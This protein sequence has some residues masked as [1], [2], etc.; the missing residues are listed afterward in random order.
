[1]SQTHKIKAQLYDN[2]LTES[3][4]DY[5]AKVVSEKSLSVEDI[6]HF[7]EAR[8]GSDISAP[9]MAH[10][11][12]LWQKE[13]ACRLCD[14]FAVSTGYF[15][16]QPNIKGVFNSP[17]ETYNPDKH[18][19]LFSFSQGALLRKELAAVEVD[20]TG[21]AN[22]T[23]IISQVIDVKTGSVN[24][25]LTPNR[26]LKILGNKLK[27]LGWC[28]EN[29]V[30]FLNQDTLMQTKVDASDIVT[31]NPSEL[32]IIIP[33]LEVGAYKVRVTTQYSSGNSNKQLLKEPRTAIFEKILTVLKG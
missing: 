25:L 11:V 8:D 27:I 9:V 19:V 24:E 7:A 13:M 4:N 3:P 22:P 10:A 1:M 20:I 12:N 31:N 17:T 26:N 18:A 28:E 15:N 5:I 14:G 29:G 6:C 33:A 21:V 23:A 2:A 16:A 32:I 30:Y